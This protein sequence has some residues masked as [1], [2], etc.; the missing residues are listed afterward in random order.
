[1]RRNVLILLAILVVITVAA[2][3]FL[4][5]PQLADL[6]ET[7]DAADAAEQE[8]VAL[9]AE[10]QRL[11]ALKRQ[12][13]EL[14]ARAAELDEAMP[15]D[16]R[17]AQFILSVQDA[18]NASGI[19]WLS[20]SQSFPTPATESATIFEINVTMSLTGGYF[21]VHDFLT[22]IETLDRAVKVVSVSLAPAEL[23]DLSASLTMKMFSTSAPPV[24]Q[25]ATETVS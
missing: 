17:L 23:P 20:I 3:L 6:R 2:A 12:A 16:P 25:G 22:R 15:A 14:R 8:I 24:P 18:A 1:M 7:R 9:E 4:F 11:E 19:D 21:Q 5:R 13:P 10:V